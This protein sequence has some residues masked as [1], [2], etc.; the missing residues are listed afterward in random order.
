M[1]K[2]FIRVAV[3]KTV[4]GDYKILLYPKKPAQGAHQFKKQKV[5]W[6]FFNFTAEKVWCKVTNFKKGGVGTSPFPA[7]G[8]NRLKPNPVDVDK[9]AG[10]G[11]TR[12]GDISGTIK[13]A[14]GIGT[15]TYEI[16]IGS[17][18]GNVALVSDPELRVDDDTS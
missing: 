18:A 4:N 16:H 13:G 10:N 3:G 14:A 12:H 8:N 1:A 17:S 7:T 15:Y 11:N 6:R 9:P 5:V 2:T